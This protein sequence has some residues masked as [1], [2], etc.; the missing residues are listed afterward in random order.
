LVP[1]GRAKNAITI[2][3]GGRDLGGKVDRGRGG[4]TVGGEGK[5]IWYWEREKD[6]SLVGQQKEY[7]QANS[8][9]RKLGEFPR[10]HQRPGR[11]SLPGLKGKDLR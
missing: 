7:K 10:M 5:V 9:N 4:G 8:G 6:L 3:V 2:G 1:L 11:K